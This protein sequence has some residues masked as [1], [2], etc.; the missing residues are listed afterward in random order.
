MPNALRE[1]LRARGFQL[2]DYDGGGLVNV[3]ATVLDLCGA[4]GPADPPPLRGI[5]PSLLS[6][7]RNIVVVL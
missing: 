4:R 1:E 3:A 5:D 2:P 6:G 7:V